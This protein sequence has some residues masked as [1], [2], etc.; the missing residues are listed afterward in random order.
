MRGRNALI[1]SEIRQTQARVASLES[2]L[3]RGGARLLELKQGAQA[4]A[5]DSKAARDFLSAVDDSAAAVAAVRSL[6]DAAQEAP[7]DDLESCMAELKT[8]DIQARGDAALKLGAYI[9]A[10]SH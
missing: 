3:S 4:I 7:K 2:L 6:V 9:R 1:S 5:E 8:L 10:H